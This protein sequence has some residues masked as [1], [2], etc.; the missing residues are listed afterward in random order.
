MTKI[1][2]LFG[3][4]VNPQ[5][6]D[7]KIIMHICNDIGAWGRGF[8]I[9]VSKKWP[10]AEQA[11]KQ[12]FKSSEG[13]ELGAVQYLDVEKNIGVANMIAQHGIRRKTTDKPPIR[14]DALKQCLQS[15]CIL[16]QE[17]KASVHAPRIGAGLAGGDWEEIEKIIEE[18]LCDKGI[19]VFVY[20]FTD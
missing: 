9:A 13:F 19:E 2:Y 3:N 7:F 5:G 15:V 8:V 16:V 11:Y 14:Y 4:A 1:N 18:E 12:W 20:D 17:K 10:V 6:K